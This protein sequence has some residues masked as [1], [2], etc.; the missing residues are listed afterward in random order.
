MRSSARFG[1]S[2]GT[3]LD[4]IVVF[5]PFERA[6]MRALLDKELAA[7]LT[8]RGLRER[9]WAVELDDS[10][11]EYIIDQ[12][13]SP[14]LGAR[15]LKRALE[16]HLL[17][18]LA[19]FI[20]EHRTPSGDQFLLVSSPGG[21]GIEVT[22]VDPDA[23]DSPDDPPRETDTTVDSELDLRSLALAPRGETSHTRFLLDELQ[24][25]RTRGTL[26]AVEGRKRARL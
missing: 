22:F 11:Y 10:A 1:P 12:G 15:P 25:I 18:R 24:R 17:A 3:G 5:R 26:D 23:E 16:R 8:R 14:A 19:A 20:V 13:F 6:Q 2:S 4:R 21:D 7:A 9:P